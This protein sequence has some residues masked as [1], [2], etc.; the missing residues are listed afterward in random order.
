M[1]TVLIVSNSY[2]G[3]SVRIDGERLFEDQSPL[4]AV[5]SLV[6]KYLHTNE[7]LRE[8]NAAF[9]T[10]TK[11]LAVAEERITELEAQANKAGNF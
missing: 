3:I 2:G 5:E 10:S 8:L 1:H 4:E 11:T 7:Q 6:Q 9:E